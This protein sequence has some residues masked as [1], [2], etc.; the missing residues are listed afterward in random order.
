MAEAHSALLNNGLR[1]RVTLRVDGG[2]RTGR[3]I[4]IAAMMG[5]E[6]FGFGTIAMI[7]ASLSSEYMSCWSYKSEGTT[8]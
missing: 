2:I 1:N 6:E 7:G 4:A 3:D 8:S 5:D